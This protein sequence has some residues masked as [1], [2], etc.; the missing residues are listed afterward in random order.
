M[1]HYI[2]LGLQIACVIVQVACIIIMNIKNK[3]D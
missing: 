3:G 2:L 1:E